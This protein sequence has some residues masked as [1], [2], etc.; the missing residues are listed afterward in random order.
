MT[1]EEILEA[2]RADPSNDAAGAALEDKIDALSRRPGVIPRFREE[3]RRDVL[4]KILTL[5]QSGRLDVTYP[6]SYVGRMLRNRSIDL[7][8]K[9]KRQSLLGDRDV[10]DPKPPPPPPAGEIIRQACPLLKVAGDRAIARRSELHRE[11]LRVAWQQILAHVCHGVPLLEQLRAAGER[12]E[13]VPNRVYVAHGRARKAV[14]KSVEDLRYYGKFTDEEADLAIRAIEQLKWCRLAAAI[15]PDDD[16][17][18]DS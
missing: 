9:A 7:H 18:E 6:T 4:T 16:D 11:S 3:A 12:L 15:G 2:L 14:R 10:V 17:E 5:L 1:L 8:R 13:D